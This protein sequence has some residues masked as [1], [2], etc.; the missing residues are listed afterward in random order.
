MLPADGVNSVVVNG[1]FPILALD[2]AN[3]GIEDI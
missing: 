2:R 3:K 1:Q